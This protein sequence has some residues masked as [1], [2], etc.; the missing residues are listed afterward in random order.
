MARRRPRSVAGIVIVSGYHYPPP[1]L[2]LAMFALPAVPL[3][4]TVL[5]HTVLPPLDRFGWSWAMKKIFVPAEI[6]GPFAAATKGMASRPSQLRSVSAE[7]F[8]MLAS[9]PFAS[10][11]YADISVP[12]GIIAGAGD[13]LFVTQTEA[14]RLQTEI[15][16]SLVDIVP[17]AG[18]MVHQSKP[19][20]VLAMIDRIAALASASEA[21]AG[22][23][24]AKEGLRRTKGADDRPPRRRIT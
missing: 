24:A 16:H 17:D 8:L 23:C 2:E 13:Q 7:S 18:H 11:R 9:A 15:G 20:A 14:L 1:R 10:R 22:A 19:Q 5:R 12:V 21:G 4:G 6:S 3:I